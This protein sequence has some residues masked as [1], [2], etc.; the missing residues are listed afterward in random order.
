[1]ASKSSG[2][3]RLHVEEAVVPERPAL[4]EARSVPALCAAFRHV[5]GWSLQLSPGTAGSSLGAWSRQLSDQAGA[6]LGVL[7]LEE[8]SETVRT[9]CRSTDAA[10][11][12]E[13]AAAVADTVQELYVTRH[14]LWQREAELAAGV[15]VTPHEDGEAHLAARLEAVL[16]AG[17]QGVRCQAAAAYLLDDATKQLKLR[18]C[19]GLPKN[20][21]LAPPRP[22]RGAV[23]DLE[24]LV[25]HAVLL[26]DTRKLTN[27]KV[28]EEFRSAV[29]VPISSPTVPF[30]TLW[31]FC[32]TPRKFTAHETSLLEIVAGRVAAD[33][34]REM[35]L[36]ETLQSRKLNRHVAQA[37]RWQ[38]SRLPR[39]KPMLNHWQ[40]AAWTAQRDDVGGDF[41]DWFVLPDGCLAVA[42]G[43]AQGRMFE[44]A[45]TAAAV[46]TALKAHAGYRH[47]AAEMLQRVNETL[48]TASSGDQFASLFYARITPD[49]GELEYAVAGHATAAVV[50]ETVR[51]V[52][53][54]DAPPL[55]M[56]PDSDYPP[57]R[58]WI[59]RGEQLVVF[60]EGLQRSLGSHVLEE[61]GA[62]I[63]R[64][65]PGDADAVTDSIH[66]WLHE[67]PA[68]SRDDQ[69]LL[70]VKREPR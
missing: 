2:Y 33:L 45:L 62:A 21:F 1:M 16:K 68:P 12:Q 44:A 54:D 51:A 60:S 35:L 66:R 70:I 63:R 25:G 3:L 53:V 32:D 38:E 14:V 64:A 30:G 69:T 7:T 23:A 42:L 5:T 20:R 67:Q 34:E 24:A 37:A 49:S 10:A 26:E 39:I 61:L 29:C 40:V 31:V 36:L 43:D 48:W 8:P 65:A 9:A 58:D 15:P 55:G 52:T 41:H 57:G 56:Q 19:W 22:L 46:H 11:V 28:P 47:T 18:S 6:D 4:E 50:G 59:G 27:W 17:A 13:L